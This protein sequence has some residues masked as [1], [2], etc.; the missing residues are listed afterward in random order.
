MVR[1]GLL[2]LEKVAVVAATFFYV[3]EVE[4][5][6]GCVYCLEFEIMF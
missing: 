2:F 1:K 6:C 4:D 5:I 3:S